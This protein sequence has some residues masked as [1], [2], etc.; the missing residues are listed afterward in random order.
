MGANW[1]D[2]LEPKQLK[3]NYYDIIEDTKEA[4][5]IDFSEQQK[6]EFWSAVERGMFDPYKMMKFNI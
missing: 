3:E 4:G 1:I 5:V 2:L 6:V